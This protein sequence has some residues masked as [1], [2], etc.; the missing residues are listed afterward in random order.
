MTF[1]PQQDQKTTAID[2]ALLAVLKDSN[3]EFF[4]KFSK[5]FAVQVALD[6][7]NAYK[8][9]N[10]VQTFRTELPPG[11][12][13]LETAV[14]DGNGKKIRIKKSSIKVQVLSTKLSMYYVYVIVRP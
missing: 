4:E 7:V 5:D 6:K 9:G 10:L 2:A 8:K 3:G 1:E 13:A 12:Y 14:M 11:A